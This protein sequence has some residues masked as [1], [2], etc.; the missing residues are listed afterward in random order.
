[1]ARSQDRVV[2]AY[3]HPAEIPVAF[4]SSLFGMVLRDRAT[5]RRIVN[6]RGENSS[7]NITNARNRLTRRFLEEDAA[8]WLVWI[9]AD[10]QFDPD[11]VDRLLDSAHDVSAPVVGALCFGIDCGRVFTTMYQFVTDEAGV[12]T[13]LR[14]EAFP[15]RGKVQV[16]ATGAACFIVHRRVLEAVAALPGTD[17][18]FPWFQE[19]SL[20]GNPVGEDVTFFLRVGGAD[21]PVYVDCG[22]RVGHQKSIIVD[23]EMFL[24]QRHEREHPCQACQSS[25]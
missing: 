1:M 10:M 15:D 20:H 23:A 17:P 18:A 19:T 14:M 7:A 24:R 11:L 12:T 21:F 16:G 25:T 13:T 22:I 8:E 5:S 4:H 2:V 6:V 9:D 3:V